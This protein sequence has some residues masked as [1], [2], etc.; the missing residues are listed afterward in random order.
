MT[1]SSSLSQQASGG[2]KN[3][4][5]RDWKQTAIITV[6]IGIILLTALLPLAGDL[7]FVENLIPLQ[8]SGINWLLFFVLLHALTDTS[9]GLAYVVVSLSLLYITDNAGKRMSLLWLFL[10]FGFFII[11]CGLMYFVV[12]VSDWR[13]ADWASKSIQYIVAFG[14]VATAV[15][16]PSLMPK[17]LAFVQSTGLLQQRKS[18]LEKQIY[19]RTQAEARDRA[20]LQ[21]L[22]SMVDVMSLGAVVF[23]EKETILYINQQCCD[24]MGLNFHP[25]LFIGKDADLY[26]DLVKTNVADIPAYMAVLQQ[27]FASTEPLLGAE[28]QLRDGRTVLRDTLPIRVDNEPKGFLFLYRDI[29]RER[30]IDAAKSEFMSL[31][32]HQLRTPLT[33]IRWSIG[34]LARQLQGDHNQQIKELLQEAKSGARRMAQTIDTMLAISRIEAEKVNIELSEVKLGA[35]L[36]DVRVEC[37]ELYELKEQSFKLDCP[38]NILIHT[39]PDILQEILFNLYTNAI[40]YTPEQGSISVRAFMKDNKVRIEVQDNGFGIPQHQQDNIFRKFFRGENIISLETE[41]TGLGLYLVFLLVK[42][43]N[44]SI[45]FV[46]L[47]GK[48]TTF[49]L[50]LPATAMVLASEL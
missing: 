47:E 25:S 17:M 21:R 41:G 12:A 34:R 4:T 24:V 8:E 35:H 18:E 50:Q 11:G 3:V 29:T 30:R 48:G 28:I 23:D 1:F 27:V 20:S 38:P 44:G 6:F 45:N 31:A 32:S 37:R 40:K 39:D 46:S 14:S 22:Q 42:L 16:M 33:A 10:I 15:A 9:V 2:I 49:I 19:E 36:N 7:F 13:P 26:F 43:L 5:N